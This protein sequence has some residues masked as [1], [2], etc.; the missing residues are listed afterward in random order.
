MIII[1]NILLAVAALLYAVLLSAAY[2][3]APSNAGDAAGG[4]AMSTLLFYLVFAACMAGVALIIGAKGGFAWT[5]GSGMSRFVL[6]A[7]GLLSMLF[8]SALSTALKFEPS[9]QVPFAVRYITGFVP[10]LFPLILLGSSAILLNAGLRE[11]VPA[12]VYKIPLYVALGLSALACL[13][14]MVEWMAY[15]ERRTADRI[16]EIQSD[17]ARYH[18]MHLQEIETADPMTGILGLLSFTGR[19]HDADV[20]EKAL[21]KIKSNPEWQQELV[22]LLDTD[23]FYHVYTFLDAEDV[24]DKT[25]FPEA[26][27]RS[28]LRMAN[29]IRQGIAGASHLNDWS[30]EYL[31]TERMLQSASRFKGMGVDFLPAVREVRAAF[32]TPPPAHISKVKFKEVKT[33]ERWLKEN[34]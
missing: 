32:D 5:P 9:S 13:V 6:V 4:Y 11:S 12:A 18:D 2:G 10:A 15:Q 7:A 28:I 14:G 24:D 22:R 30:F 26:L 29:E 20:R 31:G 23:H 34:S 21:A 8:I 16:A 25:L 19:Y 33:L 17:Q 1:G 3:P 27:N